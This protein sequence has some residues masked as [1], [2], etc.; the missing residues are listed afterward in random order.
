[1]ASGGLVRLEP[2]G[3]QPPRVKRK[4]DDETEKERAHHPVGHR[5]THDR[6]LS[7]GHTDSCETYEG[8]AEAESHLN[9]QESTD[10]KG[11][12]AKGRQSSSPAKNHRDERPGAGHRKGAAN[13][14]HREPARM[15]REGAQ[16]DLPAEDDRGP[17]SQKGDAVEPWHGPR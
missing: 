11:P 3:R 13:Q 10:G 7:S 14:M 16:Y 2:G 6:E 15:G 5:Q 12:P 4:R 1:M 9:Y 8:G 17:G